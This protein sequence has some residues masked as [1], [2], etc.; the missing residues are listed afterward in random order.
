MLQYVSVKVDLQK[1]QDHRAD[2]L[3]MPILN[4]LLAIA[5]LFPRSYLFRLDIVS[6]VDSVI[7]PER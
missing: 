3:V 1:L 7:L 5:A 6:N 2:L 4:S